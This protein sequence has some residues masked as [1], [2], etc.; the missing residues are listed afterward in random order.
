VDLKALRTSVDT[1]TKSVLE[2]ITGSREHFHEEI[3]LMFH[4][5]APTIQAEIRINRESLSYT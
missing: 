2:A 1:Q 4:V 3:Y 5:E